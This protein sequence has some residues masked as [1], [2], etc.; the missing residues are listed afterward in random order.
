[1]PHVPGPHTPHQ[2]PPVTTLPS[3]QAPLLL[4]APLFRQ[5]HPHVRSVVDG[6]HVARVDVPK[7]I[8]TVHDLAVPDGFAVVSEG[9]PR[10]FLVVGPAVPPSLVRSVGQRRC[11]NL[12]VGVGIPPKHLRLLGHQP[13]LAIP[14]GKHEF[15]I[16]Q[17]SK[18]DTPC[19]VRRGSQRLAV[20]V[21]PQQAIRGRVPGAARGHVAHQGPATV[22]ALAPLLVG[23]PLLRQPNKNIRS[24]VDRED[25]AGVD[26]AELVP[27]VQHLS[28]PYGGA[29]VAEG[30]PRVLLVVRA[31]IPSR[32]V[33]FP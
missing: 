10:V 32:G 22:L 23:Q 5:A 20:D 17:V 33:R 24:L 15:I 18:P 4:L 6:Q 2:L 11:F 16:V 13:L 9:N 26:V 8:L 3:S 7:L 14:G 28:S 27:P 21:R 31:T 19:L 30:D 25:V 29:V 1:M 12:P